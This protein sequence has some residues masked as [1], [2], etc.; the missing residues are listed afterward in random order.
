MIVIRGHFQTIIVYRIVGTFRAVL[1]FLIFVTA[2]IV[3]K[4]ST[5]QKFATVGKGSLEKLP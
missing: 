2:L 3:T 4:F 5:T 1:I